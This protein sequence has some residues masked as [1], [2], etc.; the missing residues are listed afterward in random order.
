MIKRFMPLLLVA[1]ILFST[2][3]NAAIYEYFPDV[4][5]DADY[6]YAVNHL[7]EL[8]IFSGDEKGNFNPN[9]TL[10]RAEFAVTMVRLIGETD[11]ALKSKTSSFSDVPKN[12]WACGYIEVAVEYGL[13]SGY[14]NGKFGPGDT[15]TYEQAVAIL[16]RVLRYEKEAQE[17]G[18]WPLGYIKIGRELNL[19]VNT[20]INNSKPINR[21]TVSI[22]LYNAI[23][24]VEPNMN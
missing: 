16:L 19:L 11:K 12:H 22:L 8:G 15:L 14:G 4:P 2:T 1:I 23:M 20:S 10:T 24:R 9:K 18:G 5:L 6:A 7:A 21:K 17:A 3:A 13:F